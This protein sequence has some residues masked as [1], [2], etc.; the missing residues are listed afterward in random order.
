MQIP[1]FCF[2]KG[3]EADPLSRNQLLRELDEVLL[4]RSKQKYYRKNVSIAAQSNQI[5]LGLKR[6]TTESGLQ[7]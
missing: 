4:G 3:K 1:V 6:P 7:G 2:F 5:L